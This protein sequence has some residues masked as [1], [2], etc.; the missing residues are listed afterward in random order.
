[1]V[2]KPSKLV[3]LSIRLGLILVGL[4]ALGILI[5]LIGITP[6]QTGLLYWTSVAGMGIFFI[7]TGILDAFLWPY[8]WNK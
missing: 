2:N 5:L 8:F 7:H 6:Q 4:S 3:W 1:M